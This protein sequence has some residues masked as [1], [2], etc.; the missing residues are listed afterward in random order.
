MAISLCQEAKHLDARRSRKR[1]ADLE[2]QL[3]ERRMAE[4]PNFARTALRVAA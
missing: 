2:R 3:E 4:V 1:M